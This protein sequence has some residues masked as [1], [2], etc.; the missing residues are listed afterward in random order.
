VDHQVFCGAVVEFEDVVDHLALIRADGAL[1]LADIHHHADIVLGDV[2]GFV[3]G[4]HAQ[5]RSTPLVDWRAARPPVWSA[6]AQKRITPA[7]FLAIFSGFFWAIRFG[8][9]SPNT[10]VNRKEPASFRS[11]TGFDV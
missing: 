3:L 9:S 7:T 8:T 11:R 6:A 2:F 4:V 1:F 5:H 10:R